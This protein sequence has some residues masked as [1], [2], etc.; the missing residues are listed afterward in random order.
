MSC[1]R[2]YPAGLTLI[3]V[4]AAT[5]ILGVLLVSVVLAKARY[6]RQATVADR[7]L[8]AIQAA[9]D[10]LAEWWSAPSALAADAQGKVAADPSLLWRVQTVPNETAD[11]LAVRTVRLEILDAHSGADEQPLVFVDLLLPVEQHESEDADLL[12]ADDSQEEPEVDDG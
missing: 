3:E 6:T 1:S 10:L 8:A 7:Q 11:E 2:S 4:L 12:P 9:D 5:V